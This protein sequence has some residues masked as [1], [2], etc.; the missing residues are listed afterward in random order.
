MNKNLKF[1]ILSEGQIN[2]VSA[3][4]QK[5][6]IS[7]TIYYRWLKRYKAQGIEGLDDIKKDYI[8]INKTSA[9]IENALLGLFKNYPQ[10]GPKAIKYL[11]EEMGHHISE[12]AVFNVMKRNNLTN[13]ESRIRFA[14]KKVDNITESLPPL[15]ELKS[16]ECWISWIIDYGKFEGIGNIYEYTL[17]DFKSRIACSRLYNDLSLN[18]FEN[19]LTAVAIPVAQTLNLSLRYLCFFQ[20]SR[21]IRQTRSSFH[22][23]IDEILRDHGYD[24]KIHILQSSDALGKIDEIKKQYTEG[25]LSFLLPFIHGGASFSNLKIQFQKHI[26]AYNISHKTTF[27]KEIY[28]PIDYHN[29]LTNTKLI[30]PLWAYIDRHY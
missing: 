7:R 29:K 26:R 2:G 28:T 19:L 14:K 12:S 5:Y 6:N 11:L 3:T 9:E 27:G 22:S 18:N 4:C 1:N 30:L 13:K 16:G 25:C 20:D 21:I 10:Y 24:I 17:F 23:R 15:S 8:P